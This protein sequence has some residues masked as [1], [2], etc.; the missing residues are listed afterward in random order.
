MTRVLAVTAVMAMLGA[1]LLVTGCTRTPGYNAY[2]RYQGTSNSSSPS[3]AAYDR[4][5]ST[6]K[7]DWY[8]DREM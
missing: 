5:K 1:M 3:D 4:L 8:K 7:D 2:G 6:E